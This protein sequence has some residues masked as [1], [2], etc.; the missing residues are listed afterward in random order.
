MLNLPGRALINRYPLSPH[1]LSIGM[2][3][4]V[5]S[6]YGRSQPEAIILEPREN[7]VSLGEAFT[8][9]SQEPWLRLRHPKFTVPAGRY[10][11]LI[12]DASLL[13]PLSR[14]ILRFLKAEIF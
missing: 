13:E 3:V 10:I 9:T 11:E 5:R 6:T 1:Q 4:P 2:I 14:P 12:Y 8:A 7:V